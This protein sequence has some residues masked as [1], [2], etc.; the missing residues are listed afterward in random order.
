MYKQH[1]SQDEK[2][3]STVAKFKVFLKFRGLS[4]SK[5]TNKRR[6]N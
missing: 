6:I 2:Y 4:H 3:W 5:W 1:I